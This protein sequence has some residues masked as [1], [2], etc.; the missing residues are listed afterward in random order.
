MDEP[1]ITMKDRS[2]VADYLI[3]TDN[4]GRN[5]AER[6]HY[7][8][9]TVGY[10]KGGMN[11]FSGKSNARGY[12]ASINRETESSDGIFTSRSFT[13]FAGLGLMRSE[14]VGR[15]SQKGLNA[16]FEEVMEAMPALRTDERVAAYFEPAEVPA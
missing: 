10:T 9:V 14:P 15:F 1:R 7:A 13:L 5:G 11:Y 12:Y 4:E 2:I 3:N 8:A 16:F 6:R